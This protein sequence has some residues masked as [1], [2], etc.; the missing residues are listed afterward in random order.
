MKFVATL[1]CVL[2]ALT[3]TAR[4][5]FYDGLDAYK[6][7]D[8]PTAVKEWRSL[9]V[10]G[11]ASAQYDLGLIYLAGGDEIKQDYIKASYWFRKAGE[12]GLPRAQSMLGTLYEQGFGVATNY[13]MAASWYH[14]A[15]QQDDPLGQYRLGMLYRDGLGLSQDYAQA[16]L[17]LKHAA[18]R[19]LAP[20]QQN[21]G[22]LYYNGQGVPR[23]YKDA[24][25]WHRLAA[26]QGN[27]NA[28]ITL[29]L[30]Y[31]KGEGV[32]KD[33]IEAYSWWNTAVIAGDKQSEKARDAVGAMLS[34]SELFDARRL[35]REKQA[36]IFR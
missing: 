14:R 9:A 16:A 10:I 7:G 31:F 34:P 26:E 24:L 29:G 30:M 13:M 12:Q 28:L 15:A 20:A 1:V 8:H 27:I 36:R 6:R 32:K 25:K 22:V 3:G 17:W 35:S 2:M 4:A 23:R 33:L 19:G 18:D 21:L 5:D 11:N